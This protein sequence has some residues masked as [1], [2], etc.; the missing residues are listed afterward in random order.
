MPT[1][2][3]TYL[4]SNKKV[5]HDNRC[6]QLRL[7]LIHA[8]FKKKLEIT[9]KIIRYIIKQTVGQLLRKSLLII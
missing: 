2:I 1:E 3:I 6:I 8:E 4:S 5:K 9:S 7:K